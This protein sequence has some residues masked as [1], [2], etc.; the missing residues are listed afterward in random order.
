[1]LKYARVA[2]SLHGSALSRLGLVRHVVQT[3]SI[4]NEQD[5]ML[6]VCNSNNGTY[7][8]TVDTDIDCRTGSVTNSA[9]LYVAI[10]F[11]R[12]QTSTTT[13]SIAAKIVTKMS[14]KIPSGS[15]S[16]K[17]RLVA[18]MFFFNASDSKH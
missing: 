17:I 2:E 16:T 11:A 5:Q 13:G 14:S 9:Q 1:M 4:T 15:A 8:N 10:S 3:L 7:Y 12:L 18:K 6:F